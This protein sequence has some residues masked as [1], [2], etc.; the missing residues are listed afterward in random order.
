M[1]SRIAKA[2]ASINQLHHAVWRRD[3]LT[4]GTKIKVFK[5]AVRN[6]LFYGLKCHAISRITI[7][8]LNFFC[9]NKL[10]SIFGFDF[11]SH[12][13][14]DQIEAESGVFD[15]AWTWP[16][17]YLKVSCLQ[18]FVKMLENEAIRE[19]IS[20]P[21]GLK[22]KRGRPRFRYIDAIGQDLLDVLNIDHADNRYQTTCG[23]RMV[24]QKAVKLSRFVNF[25]GKKY[26]T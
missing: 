21:K 2:N 22:R 9:L 11:D 7:K 8:K 24:D 15:I 4:Y 1:I 25:S 26:W 13:S 19:V 20:P 16:A 10:K 23:F 18:Y 17:Q 14:Y 3:N 12:V 6:I 5:A